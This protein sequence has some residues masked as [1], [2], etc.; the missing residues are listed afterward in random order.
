MRAL[1][2]KF[3]KGRFQDVPHLETMPMDIL[4]SY[5]FE[6]CVMLLRG[7]FYFRQPCFVGK[8]VQFKCRGRILLGRFVT[9]HDYTYIDASSLRG[10]LIEDYCTIGRNNYLRT[11]NLSSHHGYFIMK[12]RSSSNNN[13]FLGA[14]GGIT[15]GEN[16]MIGPNVTIIT[17]MHRIQEIERSMRDQGVES[18]P[19]V[20]ENDTWIGANSVILGGTVIE[21]GVVV[22][23]GSVVTKSVKEFEIVAGNPARVIRKRDD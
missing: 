22:G 18:A 11:G 23:A 17:E 13:C 1:L 14:T 19:V 2:I 5:L 15:I 16:V 6:R 21:T 4:L 3:L 20:I 10:I 7:L 8:G 9:I 12:K